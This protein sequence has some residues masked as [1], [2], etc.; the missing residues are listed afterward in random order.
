[1]YVRCAY[2]EG[3]VA[4]ENRERFDRF[5]DEEVIPM[6]TR[7]PNLRRVRLLRGEWFEEGAP[8]IYQTI[9]L[10]FDSKDDID[11]ALARIEANG[12]K[13]LVP[14]TG[15][16]EYGYIARFEDTEGNQVALHSN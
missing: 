3:T 16:G 8:G 13:T 14:R 2:F 7:F 11:A 15:I 12:G 10:T 5:F 6:I 4:A 1:M 9:E